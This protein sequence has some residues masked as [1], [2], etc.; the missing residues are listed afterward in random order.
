MNKPIYLSP[1]MVP[2]TLRNV[3]GYKGRK[4]RARITESVQPS[5]MEYSGGSRNRYA[6]V[7]LA[8]GNVNVVTNSR[9]WPLTHWTMGSVEIPVGFVVVMH[10]TYCGKDMGL[11]FYM[12]AENA[13]NMLPAPV[14]LSHD[15][16]VVLAVTCSLKSSYRK[17]AARRHDVTGE[18][19]EEAKRALIAAGFLTKRGAVT[20]AGRNVDT[21]IRVR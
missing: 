21:G 5:S 6:A 17:D 12:R 10:T 20:P 4:F 8:T 19:Y 11:T 18:R 15:E 1:E 3:F 2:A 14:T 13:A 7:D 9:P 16:N